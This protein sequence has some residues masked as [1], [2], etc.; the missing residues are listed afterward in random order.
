MLGANRTNYYDLAE[1]QNH[2][3]VYSVPHVTS[4]EWEKYIAFH[5]PAIH[6]PTVP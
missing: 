5:R 1:H 4:L 6:Y 2:A 3:V